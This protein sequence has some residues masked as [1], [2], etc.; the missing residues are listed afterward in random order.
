MKY[1][2]SSDLKLASNNRQLLQDKTSWMEYR[3]DDDRK[4]L[5]RERK[6]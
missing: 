4:K 5:L 6:K 3:N 1:C 2:H